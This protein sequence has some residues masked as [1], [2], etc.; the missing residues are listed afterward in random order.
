M[1]TL[2]D[3][4]TAALMLAFDGG[5]YL[6][7]R[8]EAEIRLMGLID[9][10]GP[11]PRGAA[12]AEEIRAQALPLWERG[13][14]APVVTA[15]VTAEGHSVAVEG[16]GGGQDALPAAGAEDDQARAVA[17]MRRD[18][19]DLQ[20][21]TAGVERMSAEE[22]A[23]ARRA[24]LARAADVLHDAEPA[25]GAWLLSGAGEPVRR[26]APLPLGAPCAAVW[27]GGRFRV[28][29]A[30]G[31]SPEALALLLE[32]REDL[33]PDQAAVILGQARDVLGLALAEEPV[34]VDAEEEPCPI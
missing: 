23:E 20:R 11:T 1:T 31:V 3:R 13:E 8:A 9:D 28:V 18:A 26:V 5:R 34:T 33:P 6:G 25:P 2:T 7:T 16:S 22:F 10:D 4:Q 15:E 14:R 32:R 29:V 17:R 12:V 24:D 21:A 19:E 30:E 27:A